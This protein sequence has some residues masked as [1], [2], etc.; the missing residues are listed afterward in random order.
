MFSFTRKEKEVFEVIN[1]NPFETN[2]EIAEKMCISQNTLFMHLKNM[3]KKTGS[4]GKNARH[5]MIH[6]VNQ[7]NGQL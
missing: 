6:S 4:S 5:Q 7:Q 2:R 1:E 3:F